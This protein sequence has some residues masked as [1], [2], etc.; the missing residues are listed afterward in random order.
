MLSTATIQ[1]PPTSLNWPPLGDGWFHWKEVDANFWP[2]ERRTRVAHPDLDF[3]K[4]SGGVYVIAWSVE[5]PCQKQL[6][7]CPQVKYIGETHCFKTRM[8]AFGTSA[9]FWGDRANGHSAGWSWE[10][11]KVH[12]LWVAF[13]DVLNGV[14]MP[15]HLAMG[16]RKWVEAV[17][18]EEHRQ[19]NGRL[20]IVNT[21]RRNT[22][23]SLE[24]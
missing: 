12:N 10:Q 4:D 6:H 1:I 5:K 20:P 22:I 21:V 17:A 15:T 7:T 16:L 18:L 3:I 11:G 8:G 23:I 19:V 2:K 9:G 14:E 24:D 13:F